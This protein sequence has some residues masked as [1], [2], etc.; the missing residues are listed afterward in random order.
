MG[1][2]H[3]LLGLLR[4][5]E[6]IAARVLERLGVTFEDAQ[7]EVERSIGRGEP[8]TTGQI[9]FTPRGKKVLELFAPRGD[10]A[11]SQLHRH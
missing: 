5:E 1:T 7:A 3:I 11:G 6:G 10:R 2:E 9:P 8:L 4:E